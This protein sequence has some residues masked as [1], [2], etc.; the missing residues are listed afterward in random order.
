MSFLIK[1]ILPFVKKFILK[2]L[3][4]ESNKTFVINKLNSLIDIPE[5]TETQE[6]ELIQK[7]Y[8]ALSI[9]VKSHLDVKSVD[10]Q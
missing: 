2:E 3:T 1:L 6:A 4:K 5:L 8:E 10:E 9:L 7:M